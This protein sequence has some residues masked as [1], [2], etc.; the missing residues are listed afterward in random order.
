MRSGRGSTHGSH[1]GE[2]RSRHRVRQFP[3]RLEKVGQLELFYRLF[4]GL[5]VPPAVA[6]EFA[7]SV[8]LR[9]WMHVQPLS[10]PVPN[11]VVAARL[12]PGETEA[13]AL[14]LEI[15]PVW[16]VLDERRARRLAESLT[17]PVIG[18]LGILRLAKRVGM[19]DAVAPLI[20]ALR[21]TRFF[22]DD[23][24]AERLLIELGEDR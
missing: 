6:S 18:T 15:H 3:D 8:P 23:R 22:V 13:I 5:S 20:Q 19:V 17:L 14:A 16:I 4:G 24:L 7:P 1:A 11:D 12:G 9:D 21:A 2:R 10:L